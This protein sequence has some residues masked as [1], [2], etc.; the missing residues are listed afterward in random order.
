MALCV[1]VNDQT[2]LAPG[3]RPSN[4]I[5]LQLTDDS[6]NRDSKM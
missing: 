3:Q 1:G 2:G 5:G 6:T 4:H